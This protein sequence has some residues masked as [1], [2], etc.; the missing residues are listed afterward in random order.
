VASVPAAGT[1]APDF[2][3]PATD[4]GTV[5]LS[6]LRG[7][8][9]LLAFFPAAFTSVCTTELCSFSEDYD[10]FASADTVVLPISVDNVPA[11]REFK[12]KERMRVELLSDLRREVSRAYGVLDEERFVARRAYVLI[13]RDGIVRWTFVEETSRARRENEELLRRIEE[14]G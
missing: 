13:D 10:R 5:R 1:A 8:N 9:V 2:E 11:L 7:R 3:L 4:G 12:A 6:S 14:L